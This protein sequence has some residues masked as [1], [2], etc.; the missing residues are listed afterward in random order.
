MPVTPQMANSAQGR[1]IGGLA[2][3]CVQLDNPMTVLRAAHWRNALSKVGLAVPFWAVH[4]LGALATQDG[5]AAPIAKRRAAEQAG[6][7]PP[8]KQALEL[9]VDTIEEISESEVMER[10]RAWRLTDELISVLLLKIL[11]PIYERHLGPGRRPHGVPLPLD[12]E[13]YRDLDAQLGNLFGAHDRSADL[14]FLTHLA[15]ERLRLITSV[16]Q[17]DL[18]TLRLLGMFGAEASAASALG[19]LDLLNVFSSPEANDVVNFSLDL[20]P[21]VLETKRASGQQTFSVD[22]Y[23]GLARRGTLDSLMLSELAFD[24]DLFDQRYMENEV[25]Y[26]AR[27]KQH[28]EDRRLHYIVVDAT[29]SMRGQRA[30][31]ARGLALTLIKKL[32]LRG[33]D[34]YFRFFDSRLYE[35]QHARSRRRAHDSGMNVPYV[36]CFKGEHGRNYAKVFGLLANDLSRLAKRERRTPIL[37]ILTHAECHV[38]LDTIERLRSIARL[39]GVFMLP[40]Q[41]ELDLEYVPRLHTVQVVDEAALKQREARARRAMDI[42]DDAAGEERPSML[43]EERRR[44]DSLLPGEGEDAEEAAQ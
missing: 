2:L 35:P 16:E 41:G 15:S 27:E 28:E 17:I 40:S 20:L 26:Y 25:F 10:S 8:A 18:D 7:A 3:S 13:V 24:S 32:S 11:G 29:A 38:P 37:Y 1:D 23:A 4:D 34:V 43:P 39:Y 14:R 19:M 12:P 21:S 42:I 44:R 6:L 30:V 33:E 5:G 9:W 36:L 22:G 31:F